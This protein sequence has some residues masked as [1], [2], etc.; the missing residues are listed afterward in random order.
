MNKEI[1][2]RRAATILEVSRPTVLRWVRT[3]ILPGRFVGARKRVRVLETN[4]YK[5][6]ASWV[7]QPDFKALG[8]GE[9]CTRLGRRGVQQAL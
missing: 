4:C 2:S 3:G 7:V 5:L 9:A 1:S 6:K 8:S